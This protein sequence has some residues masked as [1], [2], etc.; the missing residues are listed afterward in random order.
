MYI[1]DGNE[2]NMKKHRCHKTVQKSNIS[3][4][5][6][7]VLVN[8]TKYINKCNIEGANKTFDN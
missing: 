4:V 3:Y 5:H 7:Y 6:A 2:V 1:I 8:V